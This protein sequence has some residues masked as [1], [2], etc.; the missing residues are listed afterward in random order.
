MFK[1]ILVD[2][3]ASFV[4]ALQYTLEQCNAVEILA[5]ASNGRQAY[6]LCRKYHPD[7]VLMDLI[8]PVCDGIEGTRLIKEYDPR[9][10]VLVLTT[11]SDNGEISQALQKGADGYLLKEIEAREIIAAIDSVMHGMA[12]VH[13]NVLKKVSKLLEQ[14]VGTAI[15]SDLPPVSVSC[16][17]IELIKLVV[18][19]LS[20]QEI[21]ERLFYSEGTV[22]NMISGIL[23]KLYLKDRTQLAVFAIRNRL[24]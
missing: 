19:G 5:T 18:D 24:V 10:K 8:M 4:E 2:D 3:Q 12:V 17:E 16:K 23:A 14:P 6:H 15:S 20:N 11:F 9:I 22:K 21:A 13:G 1:L 7:L